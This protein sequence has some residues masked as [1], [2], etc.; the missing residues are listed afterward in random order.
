[1]SGTKKYMK[2]IYI[3]KKIRPEIENYCQSKNITLVTRFIN[4]Y[5]LEKFIQTELRNLNSINYLILDLQ[6]IVNLTDEDEII[7]KITLIRKMYN[8][9][10]VIIAE[11]YKQGNILLGKIFNLGIYN[12]ITAT[13]NVTF[14]VELEKVLSEEGMTFG[15]A[16]KYKIDN[17]IVSIN[18]TAKLVKE[19]YI[20]VKQTV[21]IGVI[22]TERHIGA[23]TIALNIAKYLNELT[24]IKACYIENNNNNSM[25]NLLENKSAIYSSNLDKINYK[26]IDIFLKPKNMSDILAINYNF[27][28]YDYGAL[29]E[30]SEEEIMSFLTRD[31]KIIVS[32]NKMWEIPNLIKCFQIIGE[33]PNSY[34]VFNFVNDIEKESF[35]MSLGDYWKDRMTYSEY[36]TNPFDVGNRSFFEL[37]LKPYLINTD[38]IEKKKK[39]RLFNKRGN[40]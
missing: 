35:R 19:N 9:R 5:N 18:K 8:I 21:S 2:Y 6:A 15:N 12:I 14:N 30:M 34:L 31:L 29:N 36:I 37:I 10:I 7:S 20:K 33:D 1:M 22:G 39:F 40:K 4:E 23:T 32:G 25:I 26:D 24:N 28:I 38:I 16:I 11:G 17:P 27:Y 3:S 13:D